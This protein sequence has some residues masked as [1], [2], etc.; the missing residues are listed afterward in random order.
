[1][2][3]ELIFTFQ[4]LLFRILFVQID[5]NQA[6][7]AADSCINNWLHNKESFYAESQLDE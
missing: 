4:S 5:Q 6:N 2:S 1:M 7:K 3:Q